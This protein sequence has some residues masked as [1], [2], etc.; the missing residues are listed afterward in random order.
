MPK[1]SGDI[2]KIKMIIW[3][4]DETLWNGTIDDGDIVSIPKCHISLLCDLT[5]HGIVNSI[6]S[7][8]DWEKVKTILN[9]CDI[10]NY[11]VFPSVDWSAKGPRIKRMLQV[12]GLRATNVLFIDDNYLNLQEVEHSVQGIITASPNVIPQLINELNDSGLK[13]DYEHKR[14]NQYKI[15]EAKNEVS[16]QYESNK[17]FLKYCN[18][19]V[20][21]ET[22]CEERIERIH[23]L[24]MRSNQLNF[25]K[26]RISIENLSEMLHDNTYQCGIVNV[27]DRFGDYGMVGFYAVKDGVAEHFLFSCR[28]IGMGI[29]QYVYQLLGCPIINIV[30]DVI[31]ELGSKD[32][33]EWINVSKTSAC[34]KNIE[35]INGESHSVLMKG[36]CDMD[37]VFNF[38]Q[39]NNV[40]DSE[41]T[42][43]DK[44]TGVTI[45]GS[46]HLSQI[47]QSLTITEE[48]KR[49]IA[50]DLPFATKNFY[51]TNFF[52]KKYKYIFLSLLHESHLGIY[53]RKSDGIKVVFGEACYPLTDEKYWD[54]Y[55]NQRIYTG[56]CKFDISFLRWFSEN[57]QFCGHTE[58][59]ELE[60]NVLEALNHLDKETQLIFMLGV[61]YPCESNNNV[62]F[63]NSHLVFS[64]QNKL[65]RRLTNENERIKYIYYGDFLDGQDG[66]Y[67]NI[68]HFTPAVYYKVAMKICDMVNGGKEKIAVVSKERTIRANLYKK[69]RDNPIINRCVMMIKKVLSKR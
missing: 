3:D 54:D 57:Y 40:V 49:S 34:D 12:M 47:I 42:Y 43:V 1:Y 30:G 10:L 17:E 2:A 13:Y 23:E 56:G 60:N 11:F 64:E 45:Q 39:N 46:Q 63:N 22:N 25:T 52:D 6:C 16:K 37:Q 44:E 21:I 20:S 19:K 66:F 38:I 61:E 53:K 18:I 28:T 69:F 50:R 68:Y 32:S 14:L 55:I 62:A 35:K 29:E 41:F 4:L 59:N 24:I 33:M 65:I 15:L 8:N 36:P 58:I 9:E 26:K 31:S 67:H 51:D 27:T 48:Q 7:K 5:D